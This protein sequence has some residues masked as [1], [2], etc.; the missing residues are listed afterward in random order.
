MKPNN[1]LKAPKGKFRAIG[2]N[3][4]E[5]PLADYLIG[6]YSTSVEAIEE[7]DKHGGKM[8]PAYVYDDTGELIY[9][10]GSY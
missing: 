10:I 3:V 7:A 2:V 8:Q 9:R 1:E 6:D 5:G 4:V